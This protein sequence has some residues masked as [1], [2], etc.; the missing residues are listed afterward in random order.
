MSSFLRIIGQKSKGIELTIHLRPILTFALYVVLPSLLPSPLS[1]SRNRFPYFCYMIVAFT[2]SAPIALSSQSTSQFF[3]VRPSP[4]AVS[5]ALAVLQSSLILQLFFNIAAITIFYIFRCFSNRTIDQASPEH[6]MKS[7]AA[8]YALFGLVITRNLFRTVQS[9]LPADS[10]AWTVEAYFW[11]FDATLMLLV[12]LLLNVMNS[13]KYFNI[14]DAHCQRRQEAEDSLKGSRDE[15]T[16]AEGK[17][18]RVADS[19][20]LS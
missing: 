10:P 2:F 18:A 19:V 13:S 3:S 4:S 12:A 11:V 8:V 17:M 15:E 20:R 6:D 16:G 9:F 5:S 1:L 7:H 14:H